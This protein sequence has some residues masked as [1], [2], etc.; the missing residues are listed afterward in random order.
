[1]DQIETRAEFSA[2]RYANCWEDSEILCEAMEPTAGKRLLSIAS[3]GDNSLALLA[4]GAEVVACDLSLAQLACVELR[5][6]AIKH[7]PY[8]DSLSFLGITPAQERL[9]TYQ[10]LRHGL[11]ATAQQFWDDN[12]HFIKQG[13]IHH[14][15]FERYFHFFR[16]WVLRFIHSPQKIDQL[17]QKKDRLG[18]QQY[19]EKTWAN[20]RWHLLFKIF[21]SEFVMGHL[22]RD[23]EFFRYVEVPVA[24][25]IL[26]R[27]RYALTEL[28]THDNPYLNYILTGN[29]SH[30]LPYYLQPHIYAKIKANLPNLTLFHGPIQE[31]CIRYGD[32]GFDGYNL[33]DIFEYLDS[34]TCLKLF[35][36]FVDKAKPAARLVYWNML[37]PRS[38]PAEL[39][40][41]VVSLQEQADHLFARDKAFFYS[42]FIIEEVL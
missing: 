42:K 23:P 18:R 36:L 11:S 19:Y 5:C 26:Q 33:S 17:L 41:Q 20:R 14:G 32:Q 28:P 3:A 24:E 2:I 4:E 27:T 38:C 9:K 40:D 16:R 8:D 25:S 13:F 29:F 30:S 39:R 15:K 22:G 35:Q 21:F 34:E 37:V 31:A 7:L 1:M 6:Q 10:G 12:P